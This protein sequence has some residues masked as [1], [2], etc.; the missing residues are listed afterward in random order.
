M[1]KVVIIT[2]QTAT[3]K[4]SLALKKAREENGELI[5]A[6][7]RQ[8]YKK[9]NILTNKD[10]TNHIFHK[11][12]KIGDFDIGYYNLQPKT[13]NL[14]IKIWL[15]DIV[16]PK[17]FFSAYHFEQL[18]VPLLKQILALGKTPIIVG[19]TYFYIQYLLYQK[20]IKQEEPNWELRHELALKTVSELQDILQ[21]LNPEVFDELNESDWKNPRRLMRRIEMA[22]AGRISPQM[23]TGSILLESKI[24]EPLTIEYLGLH[25]KDKKR[26]HTAIDKKIED[27]IQ[28]DAVEEVEKLVKEGY[29]EKD[30]G[31]KTNGYPE[32]MAY[33]KGEITKEQAIKK[34][35]I[36]EC[37]YAKRQYSF[38]K[39]DKN[40]H[41][42][43]V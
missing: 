34:W 33:L 38:M 5:N 26:L 39:K 29:T 7:S 41:W 8:I 37:Q 42:I 43:E 12:Q 2:G 22:E 28:H 10:L 16:D 20:N 23:N 17:Q 4:T 36:K 30:P 14:P 32:F 15:Y 3:G 25:Y 40:I 21:K 24:G 27:R 9:L 19:G 13:Y 1:K 6:D 35:R 31:M 18:T 11:K